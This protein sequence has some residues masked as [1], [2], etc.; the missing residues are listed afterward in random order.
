V[1]KASYLLHAHSRARAHTH[2]RHTTTHQNTVHHHTMNW[3]YNAKQYKTI[4]RVTIPFTQP[5]LQCTRHYKYA[6]C[7]VIPTSLI[8]APIPIRTRTLHTTI[9]QPKMASLLQTVSPA[10]I[11]CLFMAALLLLATLAD[12][13]RTCSFTD[14]CSGR[15]YTRL[16]DRQVFRD[17]CGVKYR[18]K[19]RRDRCSLTRLRG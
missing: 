2:T 10:K 8:T 11:V 7:R 13:R 6:S 15:Q 9:T 18:V 5:P 17:D 3:F 1:C 12:A 4:Q 14:S 19:A 16:R